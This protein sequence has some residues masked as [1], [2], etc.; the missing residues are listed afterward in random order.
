M[1]GAMP[2]ATHAR[3]ARNQLAKRNV[4]YVPLT[5]ADSVIISNGDEITV[6]S[7]KTP[8]TIS[9]SLEGEHSGQ[10]VYI[11]PYGSTINDLMGKVQPNKHSN[12]DAA[13][14]CFGRK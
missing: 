11:L 8:G 2:D 13:F 10:A 5:E 9:V 12:I 3:I 7:D 6:V 14:N 4:E 1:V